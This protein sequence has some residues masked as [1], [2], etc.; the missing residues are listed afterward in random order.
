MH[1]TLARSARIRCRVRV[2]HIL[3]VAQGL[4]PYSCTAC[5]HA[6]ARARGR[7]ASLHHGG[8]PVLDEDEV[9]VH[10]LPVRDVEPLRRELR[11]VHPTEVPLSV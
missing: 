4:L 11:D 2:N 8:I 6:C 10:A 7:A 1:A 3:R 5:M 9:S